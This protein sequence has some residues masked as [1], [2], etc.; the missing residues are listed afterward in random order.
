[1]KSP[2][3][4]AIGILI[5]FLVLPLGCGSDEG[6]SEDGTGGTTASGGSSPGTGGASVG[7]GGS[8]S[9]TGGGSDAYWP[10]AYNPA[11]APTSATS[12]LYHAS[13]PVGPQACMQPACHGA[14]ALMT[15]LAFGGTVYRSDGVT[16]APNVEIGVKD[17]A[18]SYFVYSA[19]NGM[20]WAVGADNVNWAAADIR[21]RNASGEIPKLAATERG[22]D[23]DSC[24]LGAELLI[25][26]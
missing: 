10:A 22:A 13:D 18:N 7:T 4:P 9:G 26:P 25:V 11:G 23:C 2:I 17:G 12:P 15:K 16:P 6:S 5:G 14:N 8:G 20:Y 21:M 24:H 19:A 1:M 3:I